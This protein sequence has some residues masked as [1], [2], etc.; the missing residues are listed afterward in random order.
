[1]NRAST[2]NAPACFERYAPLQ[3]GCCFKFTGSVART[4]EVFAIPSDSKCYSFT[5]GPLS[6]CSRSGYNTTFKYPEE[7]TDSILKGVAMY[8]QQV[9]STFDNCS[10]D[11][12][13]GESLMC[14]FFIPHCKGGKRI[15][16]C[17]RVCGEF[18]KKC[19]HMIPANFAD[20][21]IAICH[22]LPDKNDDRECFEPPNF[23]TNDS[24]KG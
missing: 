10:M 4:N 6:F 14:S 7:L 1:M 17:K 11:A 15:Y 3:F 12:I 16:P 18:L 13:V 23:K 21:L 5:D 22:M 9:V 2:K 19:L 20:Y 24:V 8:V